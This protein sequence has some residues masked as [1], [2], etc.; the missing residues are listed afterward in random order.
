[1]SSSMPNLFLVGFMGVGKSTVGRAAA[2]KLGMAFHDSDHDI[3]RREGMSISEIFAT[4]GEAAFRV[5]ERSYIENL[6]AC[7]GCVVACGGGLIVQ[8]G[9][10]ELVDS[11]GLTICLHASIETI[12]HRV[13]LH[14]HRPLLNVEDQETRTRAL[15]AERDPIYRQ[16]GTVLL[17]DSRPLPDI[18]SHVVRCYQRDVRDWLARHQG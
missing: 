7:S 5:L 11:K 15:F 4:R 9:M 1:M 10:V 12:L 13:S 2:Q 17:T 14:R 18:V 16:V 3:E 8:P 6:P